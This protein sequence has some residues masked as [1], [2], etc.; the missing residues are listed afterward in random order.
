MKRKHLQ[1][2]GVITMIEKSGVEIVG[3]VDEREKQDML[4]WRYNRG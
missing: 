3:Q 2:N 1:K 4:W